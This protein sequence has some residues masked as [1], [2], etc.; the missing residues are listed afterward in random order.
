MESLTFVWML[1]TLALDTA[2]DGGYEC[3]RVTY[4]QS[5]YGFIYKVRTY[6]HCE[7]GCCGSRGDYCCTPPLHVTTTEKPTYNDNVSLY[8][9]VISGTIVAIVCIISITCC[10]LSKYNKKN[11]TVG[12]DPSRVDVPRPRVLTVQDLENRTMSPPPA[13]EHAASAPPYTSVRYTRNSG[14]VFTSRT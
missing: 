2:A 14:K 11:V 10:V 7:H 12:A 5:N 4:K 13:Y 1:L 3:P 8:L 9:G 6:I